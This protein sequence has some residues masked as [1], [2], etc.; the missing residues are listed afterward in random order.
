MG[1]LVSVI[2]PTYKGGQCLKR[3]VDSVLAQTYPDIELI[4]V[5]DNGIGSQDQKDTADIMQEYAQ[6][7]KVKYICHDKN[8]NGSAARNTGVRNSKGEYIA[9]LD[10]D[11]ELMPEILS[12][13]LRELEKL[14]DTYAMTYCGTAYY[15]GNRYDHDYIP[16]KSGY[17]LYE[18]LSQK[19][20]IGS[21]TLCVRRNVWEELQGFDES[22]KRHQDLEFTARVA[23]KYQVKAIPQIGRKKN[24]LRRNGAKSAKA[25][26]EYRLHYLEKMKP[27]IS[28]LSPSQ[29]RD[30]ITKSHFDIAI[31]YLKDDGLTSFIREYKNLGLG[32]RG[33]KYIIRRICIIIKRGKLRI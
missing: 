25:A 16:S 17:L 7:G 23:S 9:L 19:V 18:L 26:E 6:D 31:A 4:V 24:L 21:S 14:D 10:D 12:I 5:D 32:I 29:Q 2:I 20:V 11:D 13:H 27:F 33:L 30:V 15:I 1:S 8:M 22:F 28:M 3:C